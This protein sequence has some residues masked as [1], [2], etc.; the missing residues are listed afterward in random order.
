MDCVKFLLSVKARV[1]ISDWSEKSGLEHIED[2]IENLQE[3][4]EGD[5]YKELEDLLEAARRRSES[6]FCRYPINLFKTKAI[7]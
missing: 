7:Y 2:M 6:M 1:N 4:K 3:S 5:D